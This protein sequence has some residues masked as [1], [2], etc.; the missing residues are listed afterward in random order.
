[1]SGTASPESQ[2]GKF[3]NTEMPLILNAGV[4]LWSFVNP[5]FIK[6]LYN[7]LLQ[8]CKKLLSTHLFASISIFYLSYSLFSFFLLLSY[9]P[10]FSVPIPLF[11][12]KSKRRYSL[13]L[14]EREVFPTRVKGTA[15]IRIKRQ[16][17][18]T[19]AL[20]SMLLLIYFNPNPDGLAH[21]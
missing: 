8:L 15:H 18:V 16:W 5:T 3:L 4:S 11:S 14:S 7:S 1:M 17:F 2:K 21:I 20:G 19:R 10:L 12:P 9:F 13:P 6:K